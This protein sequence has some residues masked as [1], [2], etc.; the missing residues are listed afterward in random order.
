MVTGFAVQNLRHVRGL[1]EVKHR[2]ANANPLSSAGLTTYPRSRRRT[3]PHALMT[4]A[5]MAGIAAS[6]GIMAQE[7]MAQDAPAAGADLE[8]LERRWHKCVRQAFSGQ[9]AG[10]AT[11]AAQ[12][13]ALAECK[14]LEN[15]YVSAMLVA[16]AAEAEARRQGKQSIG[17]KARGWATSLVSYV[18]E[19]VTSWIEAWRK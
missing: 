15:Q 8:L 2:L 7:A 12:K 9:P 4:A 16:Q 14:H 17:A 3:R 19:P 11:H 6:A 13:A 10:L 5:V 1:G 18:V